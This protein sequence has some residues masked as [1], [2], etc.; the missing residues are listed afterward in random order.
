MVIFTTL[1][2]TMTTVF[3]LLVG[4]SLALLLLDLVILL[5]ARKKLTTGNKETAAPYDNF[6]KLTLSAL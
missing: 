6:S 2:E 1:E 5:N 4:I 3:L